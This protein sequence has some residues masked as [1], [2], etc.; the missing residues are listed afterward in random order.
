MNLKVIGSSSKGNSYL[1]RAENETLILECGVRITDIK[2]ALNYDLKRVV[3]CLASHSHGDHSKSAK[4]VIKAGINFYSS[5][6][7]I[8][9]LGLSGHRVFSLKAKNVYQIGGFRVMPFDLIHDVKIFGYLIDHAESGRILFFT[10]TEYVKYKFPGV[11]QILC[12]ANFDMDIVDR[13][14]ENGASV[15]VRNRVIQS[16]MEIG[17]LVKFLHANDL[18]AV[19]NI[20]LIHL[21]DG[22]SNAADF[23]RRAEEAAP[24]KLVTVADKEMIINFNKQPY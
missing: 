19:N 14:I 1:L 12:E 10:D 7:T 4:D 2:K 8:E 5:L 20:V 15:F 11:N 16:H 6:E 24:G 22:N 21:S 3:G 17:T 9:A 18:T 23:K 13:N